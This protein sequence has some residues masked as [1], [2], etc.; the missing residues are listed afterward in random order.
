MLGMAAILERDFN[1]NQCDQRFAGLVELV[2]L[3]GYV[4]VVGVVRTSSLPPYRCSF[5]P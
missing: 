1:S 5:A 2:R 3:V 4:G